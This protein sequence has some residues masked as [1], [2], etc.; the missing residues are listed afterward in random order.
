MNTKIS[1]IC[2]DFGDTLFSAHHFEVAKW[3]PEV[4]RP[5]KKI[6]QILAAAALHIFD[7]GFEYCDLMKIGTKAQIKGSELFF[8]PKETDLDFRTKNGRPG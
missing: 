8:L 1:C 5:E 4:R 7:Y 6:L 2:G 3:L